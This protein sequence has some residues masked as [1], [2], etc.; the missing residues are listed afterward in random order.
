M[1]ALKSWQA[2]ILFLISSCSWSAN[3]QNFHFDAYWIYSE[4]ISP[5]S[6]SYEHD[7]VNDYVKFEILNKSN[8]SMR[9]V[10]MNPIKGN[11]YIS[12]ANDTLILALIMNQGEFFVLP[13]EKRTIVAQTI[14]VITTENRDITETIRRIFTE[15]KF[16]YFQNFGVQQ[17]KQSLNWG[18]IKI[19]KS[20][21]YTYKIE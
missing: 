19:P 14:K 6:R 2:I 15:G 7:G 13:N 10:L 16:L 17:G 18:S 1:N 11:I 5:D 4:S 12:S 9:F 3:P 20:T 21:N 8:D